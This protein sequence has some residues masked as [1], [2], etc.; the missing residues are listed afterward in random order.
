MSDRPIL[1]SG[2]M[3]RALLEGRKTQT[4]RVMKLPAVP[5]RGAWEASTVGGPGVTDRAGRPYSETPC[6]WHTRTGQCV[7]PGYAPCDLLYVREE[8]RSLGLL[9]DGQ[10]RTVR[11]QYDADAGEMIGQWPSRC[12]LPTFNARRPGMHLPSEFSRLTLRVTEV[13][14]QRLQEISEEDAKAEG[15]EFDSEPCDHPRLTC[16]EIGCAGTGYRGG[17]ADLWHSL[18]AKRGFGWDVNPWVVAV[19]FHVIAGNI[20]AVKARP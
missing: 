2:P 14:V 20:E 8:H 11:V 18:N 1:F 6:V 12:R 7:A 4:R 5:G 15:A 19:S 17:F 10:P 16:A 3:V 13:R 9:A